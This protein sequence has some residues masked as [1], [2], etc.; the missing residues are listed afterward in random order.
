MIRNFIKIFSCVIT[1]LSFQ[2]YA[3]NIIRITVKTSENTAAGIGYSV[4]GRNSGTLGKSYTG[5]GVKNKEYVFG[6]RKNSIAGAN[7]EC[8]S[9]TLTKDTT[10]TLITKGDKCLSVIEE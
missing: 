4:E 8:G 1:L 7:I 5:K 2:S 3:D 9:V 10:I 6:Y